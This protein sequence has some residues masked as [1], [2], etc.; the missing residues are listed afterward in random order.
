MAVMA[1]VSSFMMAQTTITFYNGDPVGKNDAVK[2]AD[3]MTKDGIT[4]ETTKGG[5]ACENYKSKIKEYRFGQGSTNTISSTAGKI[6]KV[7]FTCT[8]KGDKKYGPGCLKDASEGEYTFEGNIGTWTGS[9]TSFT[10]KANPQMR[11]TKIEVTTDGKPA[12]VVVAEAKDIAAFN[13]LA[14]KT[15]AKL[16]LKDAVVVYAWTSNSG[17]TQAFLRDATG[18]LL[19]YN[20]GLDLK[21]GQKLDGAVMLKRDEYDG[22]IEG[23]KTP[24]TN[25]EGYT[26]TEGKAEPKTITP[27]QAANNMSDLV[28]LKNVN[29]VSEQSGKYTNYFAE[30]NGERIQIFN[31]FHIEELNLAE[32]QAVDIVGIVSSYKGKVQINATQVPV[33]TGI[34]AVQTAERK[35]A[36]A[37]NLAG[38]RVGK[39]YKGVVIVDGKKYIKK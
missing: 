19:L 2:D 15:V 30:T 31:G 3:A 33:P 23:M 22:K 26:A 9:A 6:T 39:D 12:P 35:D 8:A 37:Y 36:P 18:A 28:I 24:E 10:F 5:F 16:T 17:N 29:I 13:A 25:A 7:V 1:L 14:N 11:A 4:I 38:Q 27:A 34:N 21:A 20:T 32:A